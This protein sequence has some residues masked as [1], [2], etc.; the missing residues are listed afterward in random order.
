MSVLIL[1]LNALFLQPVENE[2]KRLTE[3]EFSYDDCFDLL[4]V[5]ILFVRAL[6]F[7]PEN[8]RLKGEFSYDERFDLL[9]VLILFARAL[10][11]QPANRRDEVIDCP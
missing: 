9:S 1:L 6:L 7:Q 3:G 2:I 8:E 4:S 5:L 10:P 11:L